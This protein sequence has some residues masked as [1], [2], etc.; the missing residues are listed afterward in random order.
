[1]G[2]GCFLQNLSPLYRVLA[3]LTNALII[4]WSIGL[5]LKRQTLII[6]LLIVETFSEVNVK[7]KVKWE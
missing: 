2:H 4:T 6:I 5:T 3:T 1:M 7:S